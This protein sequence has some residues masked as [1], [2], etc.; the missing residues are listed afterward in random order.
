MN[1]GLYRLRF[2]AVGANADGSLTVANEAAVGDDSYRHLAGTLTH[3]GNIVEAT[4][5]VSCRDGAP[6]PIG[7]FREYTVKFAGNASPDRFSMIGLGPL[8][9]IVELSGEWQHEL[10]TRGWP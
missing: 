1:D 10:G 4:I 9:L 3:S 2:K 6:L 5:D 8:G 7:G